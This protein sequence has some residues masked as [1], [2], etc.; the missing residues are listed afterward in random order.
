MMVVGLLM[1]GAGVGILALALA[2]VLGILLGDSEH[3]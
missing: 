1:I 3:D 2:I